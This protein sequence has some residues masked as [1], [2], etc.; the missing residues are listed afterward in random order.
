[1]A[2][3]FSWQLTAIFEVSIFFF[4]I[5]FIYSFAFKH[6][7]PDSYTNFIL[8]LAIPIAIFLSTN[9]NIISYNISDC[10]GIIGYLWYYIYALE[11]AS[12]LAVVI[13]GTRGYIRAK[14]DKNQEQS[15]KQTYYVTI[16][17]SSFLLIFMGFN[18]AAE[19]FQ[20][21]QIGL[22]GPAGM[23]IFLGFLVYVIVK[24]KAF[25][26]KLIG[27]NVLVLVL[28]VLIGS[29]LFVVKSQASRII[30]TITLVF[31]ILFGYFLI[32]SV[33]RE[34]A[35]RE[36]I[37]KLAQDLS[38]SNNKLSLANE[39]LKE[40]DQQKTEFV[41][42]A[43]HQLRGPL[44]VIKGYSSMLLE[45]SFGKLTAKINH[46][47]DIIFRSSQR[48]VNIIEDFL[49]VTRIEL[50][51]MH[52]DMSDFDLRDMVARSVEE[53]KQVATKK[54]L[55]LTL[56]ANDAPFIVTG[57]SGKI[58]QVIG[59]L[60]DNAI[61]YTPKGSIAVALERKDAMIKFSVTDS[62]IGIAP[63]SIPKLFQKFIRADNAGRINVQGTGLGLYVAKQIIDSHH[64][65][66]YAESAGVGKGSAFIVELP[67]VKETKK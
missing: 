14:L 29:I 52:Y 65:K 10:E 33:R 8:L 43:S 23:T 58:I 64:G 40:L 5:Y 2:L 7:L 38:L 45:G 21:Y 44:T 53:F 62:G 67:A 3:M 46:P 57:D 9:W 20:N 12:F 17:I 48:L 25:N 26:I 35:Q 11:L 16:G 49:N 18:V 63:D 31:S 54:G 24:F 19:Y 55:S 59:N 22:V 36:K 56:Q 41:S 32:R 27:A 51:T 37:E 15:N 47:I 6:K 39:R 28:C 42:I 34:V 60:I 4:S 66:I 1:M 13:I 61:K 50:G 30:A